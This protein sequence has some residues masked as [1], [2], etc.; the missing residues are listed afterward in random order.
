MVA[1]Y[2]MAAAIVG[3]FCPR[4]AAVVPLDAVR[5]S[6]NAVLT[7]CM[8]GWRADESEASACPVGLDVGDRCGQ[9]LNAVVGWPYLGERLQGRRSSMRIGARAIALR[10]RCHRLFDLTDTFQAR[11]VYLGCPSPT[12]QGR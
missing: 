1:T 10:C 12:A 6:A 2:F 3:A 8:F 11:K 9:C 7:C 4:L 5:N